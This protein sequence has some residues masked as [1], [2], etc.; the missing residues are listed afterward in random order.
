MLVFSTKLPLKD[1]ITQEEC[2]KL[3]IKWV[4]DSPNYD[5]SVVD[6]DITSHKDFDCTYGNQIFSIRHFKDES[7]EISACRLENREA[8]AIWINDCIF[9]CENNEKFLLIQ[10]HCN[11]TNFDIKLPYPHK[12]YIV[13]QFIENEYCKDDA[14][15]PITDKPIES[16]G[17]YYSTCVNFMNG[18]LNYTMPIVYISCDY[19]GN[20]A[21]SPSYLS[22]QLSGVAHVFVERNRETA[23][24]LKEDTDGNNAHSEYIGIYFPGTKFCQKYG[25]NYYSN[26]KAMSREIINSVWKVLINKSDSSKFNWNH[27]IALQSR[28]K[29]AEWQ[30]ISAQDKLQLS[31]YMDTFDQ[32]NQTL[33]DKIDEMSA[34]LYSVRAQLDTMR[35]SL[36]S[37]QN[38]CFYRSGVETDLYIGETSDLLHNI[39]SHAQSKFDP[40]SRAFSLIQSLLN[41]NPRIGECDRIIRGISAIFSGDCRLNKTAKTQLQNLGFTIQEDGPHYKMFFHDPRYMFTVSKTPSDHREG[42]NLISDIKNIIDV[43]RKI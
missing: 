17:E 21:I 28:Q 1:K 23:L 37:S 43:E 34:E 5:I 29:M 41:A 27:I 2:M 4:I 24:K 31:E 39:L 6:Y 18:T 32:E 25:L 35:M 13:R 16:D 30:N 15:I 20:T 26:Y 33:R 14:G 9:L 7:I 12:P 38:D 3:F 11:R 8:D 22:R 10:L 36:N 42:K 19:W 40:N